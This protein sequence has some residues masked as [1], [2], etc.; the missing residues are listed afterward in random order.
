VRA[1][2]VSR[3]MVG[4]MRALFLAVGLLVGCGTDDRAPAASGEHP[5]GMHTP[6]VITGQGSLGPTSAVA[7]TGVVR[8]IPSLMRAPAMGDAV[9]SDVAVLKDG[10]AIPV[11]DGAFDPGGGAG[12]F[13]VVRG[14]S[15]VLANVEPS[16]GELTLPLIADTAAGMPRGDRATVVL[17]LLDSA[18]APILGVTGASKPGVIGPC[19]DKSSDT[20]DDRLPSTGTRGAIA[21]LSIDPRAGATFTTELTI[22]GR[23]IV[24]QVPVVGGT[25]TLLRASLR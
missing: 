1:R 12:W 7:R 21:Y 13:T 25:V 19:Y 6:Q 11:R 10:V 18:G 23:P 3:M 15:R 5:T 24:A 22:G 4:S 2:H 20:M 8:F 9:P 14:A 17:Q 16:F